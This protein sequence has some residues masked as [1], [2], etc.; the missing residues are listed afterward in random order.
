[1]TQVEKTR[2]G[3]MSEL[4]SLLREHDAKDQEMNE[5]YANFIDFDSRSEIQSFDGDNFRAELLKWLSVKIFVKDHRYRYQKEQYGRWVDSQH[6]TTMSKKATLK[7]FADQYARLIDARV[8]ASH[9]F[10]SPKID[11]NYDDFQDKTVM[12]M[13]ATVFYYFFSSNR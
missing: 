5:T 13:N 9:N 1:M 12:P 11:A 2:A 8:L 10:R 3:D 7:E 4:M 6:L